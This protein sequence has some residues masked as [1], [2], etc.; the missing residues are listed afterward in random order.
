M[1]SIESLSSATCLCELNVIEP[2]SNVCRPT[3]LRRAWERGQ[4]IDVHGLV[5]GLHDG[6]L[7][8]IGQSVCG[9]EAGHSGYVEALPAPGPP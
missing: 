4:R 9:E 2:V 5:Y 1:C 8:R 6:L 3:I 7:R